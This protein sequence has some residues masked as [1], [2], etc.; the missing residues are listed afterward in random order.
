LPGGA[1]VTAAAVVER[2]WRSA[3]HAYLSDIDDSG[4]IE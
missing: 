4:G 3:S 2:A 1:R